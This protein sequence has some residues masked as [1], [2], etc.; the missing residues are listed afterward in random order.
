[1]NDCPNIKEAFAL[2]QESFCGV[3]EY[4]KNNIQ[5]EYIY[6]TTGVAEAAYKIALKSGLDAQKAYIGGLLHDY[7]KIQNEK[8]TDKSHFL[9]GYEKMSEKKYPFVAKICLTHSFP[10]KNFSYS[11]Y[12]SYNH[13]DLL[14]TKNILSTIEYDDYDRL[15]QFCDILFEGMNKVVYQQR[16][17]NI[18]QRYN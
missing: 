17:K 11:D 18:K 1:M 13:N 5:M 12:N 3:L 14:K 2:W 4:S 15:I 9:L 8:Q 16:L 7:G 10:V 6:H